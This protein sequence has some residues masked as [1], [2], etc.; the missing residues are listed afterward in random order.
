MR[1]FINLSGKLSLALLVC[2]LLITSTPLELLVASEADT[3]AGKLDSYIKE[4]EGTMAGLATIVIKDGQ[5]IFERLTGYADIDAGI[6]INAD[7]VFEWGS[8]SKLLIWISV[9]QLYEADLIDL[10]ADIR[11]YL[12]EDFKFQATEPVSMLNLMN[13]NAGF[14]DQITDLMVAAPYEPPSL[15]H[16]L[17]ATKVRQ[18]FQPGQV[19]AY[20]NYGSALAAYI[21]ETISG[22]DY[23]EYVKQNIFQPLGMT[24]T[25]ID[26]QLQDNVWVQEQRAK[27][28]GYS[29]NR[30][31]ITP[32][33]YVIPIYPC[34]SAVGTAA[35]MSLLLTALL[36]ENGKPLFKVTKTNDL[37]CEPTNY[38]PATDIPRIAHGLFALP[39]QGKVCGHGGNTRAFSSALYFDR[40]QQTGLLIMTNQANELNYCYGIAELVFG[41]PTQSA[42]KGE[43]EN[44]ALWAG[45]Y[46]P[47]R[48]PY[49]GFS[50]AYRLVNRAV[51]RS[52]NEH[53]LL[54]GDVSYVQQAP[55]I[56]LTDEGFSMFCRDTFSVH[57]LY[58]NILA[59]SY[60]DLITVS[61]WEYLLEIGLGLAL[62][63]ALLAS[64][65][66]ILITL[67]QV[68][69]KRGRQVNP[70]GILQNVLNVLVGLNIG[71]MTYKA[72]SLTNYD[73]LKV[74][75]VLVWA[76]VI[77]SLLVCAVIIYRKYKSPNFK[78]SKLVLTA[79]LS[80]CV[81]IFNIFYWGLYQ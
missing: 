75:F 14:E 40:T 9:L 31:L 19:V 47:A 81:L 18:F 24:Q 44:S 38:L 12:P 3:L 57:P 69:R 56:Y 36:S 45:V 28:R 74:H 26:P 33:L 21:V 6:K 53:N 70:L 15:R 59:S 72:L 34:G 76:Y 7:T 13:H 2:C 51:V 48:M 54:Y 80:A 68:L 58:G 1:R 66:C 11:T 4:H 62:V 32:D 42:S 20:S 23:R 39:A 63:L 60:G 49:H 67:I 43:L 73:A 16:A 61:R 17:E 8:C 5:V 41:R 30:K 37:L 77:V 10:T 55:G 46:Q 71:W 65:I 25:S 29:A 79:F 35:D 52:E 22:T 27:I 64:L 50:K 78:Y